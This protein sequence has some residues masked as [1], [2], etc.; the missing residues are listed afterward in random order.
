MPHL[1]Q[2]NRIQIAIK[3]EE[4][5]CA[6]RVISYVERIDL[7]TSNQNSHQQ[8]ERGRIFYYWT[9]KKY[10]HFTYTETLNRFKSIRKIY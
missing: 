5:V 1:A 9:R 10:S 6:F 3:K 2:T 8:N 4:L 7:A